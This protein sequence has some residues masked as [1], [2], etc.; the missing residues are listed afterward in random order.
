VLIPLHVEHPFQPYGTLASR[1][2]R[3]CPSVVLLN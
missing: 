2:L 3:K 1:Q